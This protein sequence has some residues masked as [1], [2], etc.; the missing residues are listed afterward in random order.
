[1]SSVWPLRPI[2]DS[3]QAAARARTDREK[4]KKLSCERN[5][6][7][8]GWLLGDFEIG[9]IMKSFWK[10]YFQ[11]QLGVLITRAHNRIRANDHEASQGL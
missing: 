7:P 2:I 5:Y 1:M 9:R 10:S 11:H 6:N 4:N 8:Q 3:H